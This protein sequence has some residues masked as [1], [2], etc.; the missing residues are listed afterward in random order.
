MSEPTSH[1]VE[2]GARQH[3]PQGLEA[4]RPEAVNLRG[5]VPGAWDMFHVGHLNI[6]KRARPH[7]GHL[8]VGVV[9]DEALYEMKGKYPIV[10]LHERMEIVAAIGLV[11]EVVV[12]FSINKVEVWKRVG[13]DVLFKGSDWKGTA[14]GRRLEEDMATV[15]VSVHYF[16]Y[17]EQT[18]SSELRRALSIQ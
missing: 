11:D 4:V 16:P 8:I 13:F 1:L 12:D 5:Y 18:S 9:T 2:R 6:I 17:T 15:G 7:C 3:G 10:P 14:K